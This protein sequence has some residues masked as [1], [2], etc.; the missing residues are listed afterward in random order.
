MPK[1]RSALFK[2]P[3][4]RMEEVALSPRGAHAVR[5]MPADPF[6]PSSSPVAAQGQDQPWASFSN[7]SGE[8]GTRVRR[9]ATNEMVVANMTFNLF[10]PVKVLGTPLTLLKAPSPGQNHRVDW[11]GRRQAWCRSRVSP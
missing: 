6:A 9:V 7:D 8:V 10:F 2:T 1:I 5:D 3:T 11:R 4:K